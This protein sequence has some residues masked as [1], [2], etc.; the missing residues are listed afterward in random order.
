MEIGSDMRKY[1]GQLRLFIGI[2]ICL[3]LAIV[4]GLVVG[5]PIAQKR[6]VD[7]NMQVSEEVLREYP[8][9]DG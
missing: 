3:T 4:I 7:P 1:T 6:N 2:A 8:L 9:V 5:I